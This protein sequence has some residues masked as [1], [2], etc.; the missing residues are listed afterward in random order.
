MALLVVVVLGVPKFAVAGL[1]TVQPPTGPQSGGVFTGTYSFVTYISCSSGLNFN[2]S[3][4]NS[5]EGTHTFEFFGAADGSLLVEIDGGGLLLITS[6]GDPF[7]PAHTAVATYTVT[8][9]G[10]PP[11]TP[12]PTPPPT[13]SPTLTP[14]SGS[15]TSAGGGSSV[16]GGAS[17]NIAG[18]VLPG[19]SP[20]IVATPATPEV[21]VAPQASTSPFVSP[22]A[23]GTNLSAA[24]P[25]TDSAAMPT[26]QRLTLAAQVGGGLGLV[27]LGLLLWLLRSGRA[28]E[29]VRVVVVGR[30]LSM[31]PHWFRLRQALL[32]RR[33]IAHGHDVPRRRGLSAHHHTG[34]VL[35]HHH[36]SYPALA[37]LILL[38]G[39]LAAGVSLST[40][41]ESS[42]LTVTVPGPPPATPAT[43]DSP[44]DGQHF[45]TNMQTIRGTCPTGLGLEI[46]RNASFAGSTL[47]DVNG[48]YAVLITLVPGAN[49]IVARDVDGLGQYG[50][51]SP[52]VTIYYDVPPTPTPSPTPTAT[53][54]VAPVS[55]VASPTPRLGTSIPRPSA[56][57]N[58]TTIEPLLLDSGKHFYYGVEVG[59]PLDI[60][61]TARGGRPPY[62]ITWGW[63][64]GASGSTVSQTPGVAQ[65]SHSYDKP[66]TYQVTLRAKD[67]LGR[68]AVIQVVVVVNGAAPMAAP[69]LPRDYPGSLILVWP[70]LVAVSLVVLSFWLGERHRW[71]TMRH[72]Y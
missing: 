6:C 24:Q 35:A 29:R 62:R 55:S 8:K 28:R 66:G 19:A 38:S 52:T 36:T 11:S 60:A 44:T 63:G 39:V 13:P 47:C 26:P 61:V 40:R 4:Q 68:E 56:T 51:D 46:Y 3:Y 14:T 17:S 31:E 16:S 25:A 15:S 64:D 34:K 1:P 49:D 67:A 32:G 53:P 20:A 37:F 72:S 22:A 69:T 2:S 54:S 50:P 5:L 48:L 23:H 42:L 27:A 43:I 58:Q 45:S 18:A 57:P 33:P 10:A 7:T 41:A 65:N 59:T 21:T 70:S 30:W 9:N 12:T 71:A